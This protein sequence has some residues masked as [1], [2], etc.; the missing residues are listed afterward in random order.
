[1]GFFFIYKKH[2]K[3]LDI[4]FKTWYNIYIEL[5]RAYMEKINYAERSGELMAMVKIARNI[6]KK[7]EFEEDTFAALE[8]KTW[9]K[10][11]EE[12]EYVQE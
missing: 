4:F 1:V 8:A 11:L 10:V 2:I 9:L 7:V 3:N 5:R 12:M 6:I